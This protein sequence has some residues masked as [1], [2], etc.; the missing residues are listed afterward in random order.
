MERKKTLLNTDLKETKEIKHNYTFKDVFDMSV[1]IEVRI[2]QI[3]LCTDNDALTEFT[4]K[5]CSMYENSRVSSLKNY[6][7]NIVKKSTLND[8]LKLLFAFSYYN[9]NPSDKT[10]I[11][12]FLCLV[13]SVHINIFQRANI[14][15][16]IMKNKEFVD[17]GL[18]L[19][20]NFVNNKALTAENRF[21]II[22]SLE[23]E[24]ENWI[25][26][27][28]QACLNFYKN[29]DVPIRLRILSIQFL[30]AKCDCKDIIKL[31]LFTKLLDIG[32][33]TNQEY[34]TRADAVDLLLKFSQGEMLIKSK[35]LIRELGKIN[36][37]TGVGAN[38]FYDNAQNVHSDAIVDSI[39]ASLEKLQSYDI[40]KIDNKFIDINYVQ[41]RLLSF[42]TE[43][44]LSYD[45]EKITISLNRISMDRAFYG[46]ASMPL[47]LVL[48][49]AW[50][51]IENHE[52]LAEIKK[53]LAE[54]LE[55][56]CDLCSSGFLTAIVNSLSAY[57][58]EMRISWRDQIISNFS[59]RFNKLI[60]NMDN[61]RIR[62]FILDEITLDPS[63]GSKRKHLLKFLRQ[64]LSALR[65]ELSEEF[66]PHIN[67]TDFDIYFRNAVSEYETGS[68]I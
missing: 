33:D 29:T 4:T 1:D 22:L 27:S 34:N 57:G 61:L 31:K 37:N 7:V 5:I 23:T 66:L 50:S 21:K 65:E 3:N 32:Q 16:I 10:A 14:L 20:L 54:E 62:D 25:Y 48:I 44:K 6:I 12:L 55:L 67:E 60:R 45:V 51:Y 9:C 18:S 13:E 39:E 11:E 47:K 8:N 38:T 58:F 68:Y 59:G 36:T 46:K 28:E 30:L 63:E 26:F 24:I 2:E 17:Q 49:K 41:N 52:S 40:L 53:R 56:A 42:I 19:F 64:N 43:N 35:K 15:L